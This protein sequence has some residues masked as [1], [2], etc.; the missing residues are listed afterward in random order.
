M[1]ALETGPKWEKQNIQYIL[2]NEF[3]DSADSNSENCWTTA[4]LLAERQHST[5]KMNSKMKRNEFEW[6]HNCSFKCT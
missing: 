2:E 6:Q 3:I 5:E 1:D 4:G